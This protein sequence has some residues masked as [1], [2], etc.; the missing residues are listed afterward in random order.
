MNRKRTKAEI[1]SAKLSGRNRRVAY[2]ILQARGE[3]ANDDSVWAPGHMTN[4]DIMI[5]CSLVTDRTALW[6]RTD[7][8]ANRNLITMGQHRRQ[9]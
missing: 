1:R 3:V 9:Q 7:D 8:I 5:F 2:A 6:C 4:I